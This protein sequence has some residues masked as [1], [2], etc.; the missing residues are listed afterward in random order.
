LLSI[1][2][3]SHHQVVLLLVSVQPAMV[4]LVASA[5]QASKAAVMVLVVVLVLVVMLV[6]VLVVVLVLVAVLA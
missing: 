5:H 6:L 3:F 2:F 1:I 4:K